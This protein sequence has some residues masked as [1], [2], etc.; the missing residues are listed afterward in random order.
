DGAVRMRRHRWPGVELSQD[1]T[2]YFDVHHTVHDTLA[3][4]DAR[5]LPQNVACWAVV[6]WL[7]AQSPLAFESAG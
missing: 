1:G 2:A 3:R 7:A 6:A 4:M 5:A